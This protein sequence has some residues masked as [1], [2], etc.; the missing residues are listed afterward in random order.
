MY[1]EEPQAEQSNADHGLQRF[2]MGEVAAH[3][4]DE[5]ITRRIESRQHQDQRRQ[6][7]TEQTTHAESLHATLSRNP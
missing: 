1:E 7:P 6:E 4:P 2:D 5:G 3:P